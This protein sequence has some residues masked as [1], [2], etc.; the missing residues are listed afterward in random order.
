MSKTRNRTQKIDHAASLPDGGPL[1]EWFTSHISRRS[2]GKG[3]AWAAALG[4]AGVTIYKFSA[5]DSSEASFDSLALQQKEGW[6][7]GSQDKTLSFSEGATINDSRQKLWTSADQN[8]LISTYQPPS[9]QWQP[10]FVPTLI[11]SLAQPSLKSQIRPINTREMKETYERAEGLRNL[12]AQSTDANKTLIISDL[13]GP[14]SVALGAALAETAQLVPVFDNWPHPL[15][16]VRSHETLGAMLYYAGE[17]A[18]KKSKTN[19]QSPVVM[20]L[21]SNRFVNQIDEDSQFDNRYIG[22]LPATD[23]LKERGIQQVIYLVKDQNQL[24]EKD[25]IN[26]DLVEWE[27]NGIPVRMLRL[28]EFKPYEETVQASNTSTTTEN[29]VQRNY[30]YG[31]SPLMHWWFFSHYGYLGPREM[32][33]MRDGYRNT[34]PRPTSPSTVSPPSYRPQ[35]RPTIF[36]ASRVGTAAGAVGVGKTR[37]SGFGRTSVRVSSDGRITGTRMRGSGSYGRGGGWFG[38]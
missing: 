15:G 26:D 35:S 9:A 1:A 13:P 29:V 21:D 18:E 16:V 3:M 14:A 34:I 28:S 6:N 8:F 22:K 38:G 30:Y 23:K 36:N 31:G 10:F 24:M 7:V 5:G 20:L 4:M 37:P 2:L 11:Q 12:I 19:E 27:K 32:V 33:V 25:D 17:I